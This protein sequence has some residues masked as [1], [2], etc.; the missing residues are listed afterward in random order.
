MGYHIAIAFDQ[1]YLQP[2]FA[3]VTSIF[4]STNPAQIHIHAIMT[5]VCDDDRH[6]IDDYIHVSGSQI[7]YYTVADPQVEKFVTMGTWTKAVYYRL[8]FPLLVPDQVKILLYLDTDTLVL[9]DL[10]QLFG[11]QMNE[12]PVAAVYD[13]YV[14][15]QPLLGIFDEGEYFN[16]GMLLIDVE[17][18]REQNI[19]EKVMEYLLKYPERIK[20]VDQCGLNAVLNGNWMK[21]PAR[22]NRIFTYLPEDLSE[23]QMP[24]IINDTV[25][26]HFTLQRPWQMLCKNRFRRLYKRY[27]INS[28]FRNSPVLIDFSIQKIPSWVRIRLIEFYNDHLI[29]KKIWRAI[30]LRHQS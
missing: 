1:N 7:S 26:L 5:G 13:N 21:L 18:W 11:Q 23:D 12:F 17:K 6:R 25:V 27:L 28:P 4:Q 14:K 29:I 22:F 19:S 9:N 24:A 16:S 10:S 2:F 15:S 3:L 30:K 20:F 8:Y